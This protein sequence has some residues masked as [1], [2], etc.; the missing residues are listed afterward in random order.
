MPESLAKPWA[1]G[2]GF[3]LPLLPR[4]AFEPSLSL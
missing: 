1:L 3:T 2:E 4:L